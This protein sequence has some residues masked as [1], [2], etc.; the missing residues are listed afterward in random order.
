[1]AP[2]WLPQNIQ[3]KVFQYIL[4]RLQIFSNINHDNI[5]VSFE[6]TQTPLSLSLKDV[7]LDTEKLSVLSGLYVRH[8]KISSLDL[9]LAVLGG[10][11][12]DG[13]GIKLIASLS[14]KILNDKEEITSLLARTTAD[15]ASSILISNDDGKNLTDSITSSHI[16]DSGSFFSESTFSENSFSTGYGLGDFSGFYTKVADAAI[17]QLNVVLRDINVRLIL[18]DVTLD[19]VINTFKLSTNE[20]G[21][22]QVSI[23]DFEWILISSNEQTSFQRVENLNKRKS[24]D[25]LK[26]VYYETN[27]SEQNLS[28]SMLFSHTDAS[29]LYMSAVSSSL[30]KPVFNE[31]KPKP[32]LLWCESLLLSFS[33]LDFSSLIIE[34]GRINISLREFP[35]VLIPLLKFLENRPNDFQKKPKPDDRKNESTRKRY[36]STK[37][38]DEN[39]KFNVSR[40]QVVRVEISIN[41][42]ML[43][44]GIFEDESN[45][46]FVFEKIDYQSKNGL[47]FFFDIGRISLMRSG[48]SLIKFHH[49]DSQKNNRSDV[50]GHIFSDSITSSKVI[51]FAMPF[52][53]IISLTTEDILLFQKCL[54]SFKSTFSAIN[55]LPS[56]DSS[57]SKTQLKFVGQTSLIKISL[58]IVETDIKTLIFPIS[59]DETGTISTKKAIVDIN[60]N[61]HIELHDLIYNFRNSSSPSGVSI[62][63]IHVKCNIKELSLIRDDFFTQKQE[64]DKSHLSYQTLSTKSEKPVKGIQKGVVFSISIKYIELQ[65]TLPSK[66][67]TLTI[68]IG[69]L[70]FQTSINGNH[71]LS[72]FSLHV[73]R[74]MCDVEEKLGYLS[75]VHNACDQ[76]QV[77]FF[78]LNTSLNSNNQEYTPSES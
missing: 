13:S 61:N 1:M 45:I 26:S 42:S 69:R 6:V 67:Q 19:I 47:E 16:G 30:S 21:L 59:F 39:P 27:K 48:T 14:E 64:F 35:Q 7:E 65:I 20:D 15:L 60:S 57:A 52:D 55:D 56:S 8:G 73:S 33:G 25:I 36:D 53:A 76:F 54:N 66:I 58:K 5:D 2:P 17:S 63:S 38:D 31:S 34:L 51:K 44:H 28:E 43:P 68:D 22:R 78:L 40:L 9:K 18:E 74:D 71:L 75:I 37:T 72:I 24:K 12:I 11:R 3:K 32:R 4:S 62:Q 29:S 70:I 23:S 49:V 10:I 77:S 41:S 46:K 50:S